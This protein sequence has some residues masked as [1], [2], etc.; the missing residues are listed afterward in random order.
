MQVR[1][2]FLK[3]HNLD[4]FELFDAN[5]NVLPKTGF[6]VKLRVVNGWMSPTEMT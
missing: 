1:Y 2:K 4:N 3:Y 5:Q 6:E